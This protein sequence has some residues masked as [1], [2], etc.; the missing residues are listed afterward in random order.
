MY[1][2]VVSRVPTFA[3]TSPPAELKPTVNKPCSV[4]PVKLSTPTPT[5]PPISAPRFVVPLT[6]NYIITGLF[7]PI[8]PATTGAPNVFTCLIPTPGI[9]VLSCLYS[10]YNANATDPP[11]L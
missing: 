4:K 7:P 8:L 3:P 9:P 2:R 1:S 10:S 5:A 6:T 11:K